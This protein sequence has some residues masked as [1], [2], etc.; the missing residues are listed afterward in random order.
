MLWEHRGGS[1]HVE[2]PDGVRSERRIRT[3]HV[4]EGEGISETGKEGRWLP[5]SSCSGLHCD[6]G[7]S[8][9]SPR[10]CRTAH[11][12]CSKTR[13][14]APRTPPLQKDGGWTGRQLERWWEAAVVMAAVVL[15]VLQWALS[16]TDAVDCGWLPGFS[17]FAKQTQRE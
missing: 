8:S 17:V 5:A 10:S 14:W 16:P 1:Q 9:P 15:Q 2:Q 7:L 6:S 4:V 3:V 12:A 13:S 11:T